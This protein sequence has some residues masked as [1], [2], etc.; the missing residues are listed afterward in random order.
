M[1]FVLFLS[2][3]FSLTSFATETEFYLMGR[4]FILI[5]PNLIPQHKPL[6]APLVILL[7]G[8]KQTAD[9]IMNGTRMKEA[10]LRNNFF[11]L[12]PQQE[13]FYN[14]DRCW[15]W[16]F[17]LNQ[18]RHPGGELGQIITAAEVIKNNH[19]IDIE[20]IFAV[21]MSSGGAMAHNLLACYPDY[22]KGIAVHSGLAFKIAENATEANE[23]LTRTEQK[24]PEMLGKL[25]AECSESLGGPQKLKKLLVIH[26]VQD[27][28]VNPVHASLMIKATDAMMKY[29]KQPKLESKLVMVPH[30]AHAWGGGVPL[31]PNFDEKAPS[32]TDEILIFFDLIKE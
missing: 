18:S 16:F 24:S 27:P 14:T 29:L 15:N 11:L 19:A 1:K 5:T 12:I 22:F 17:P 2:L 28:R 31:S 20:K 30:L 13:N 8:C 25:A 4:K 7:H 9:L 3:F 32:S 26:G 10:A 6:K 23:V 21:G